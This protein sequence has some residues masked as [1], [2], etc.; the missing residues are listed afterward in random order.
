MDQ[1]AFDALWDSLSEIA[2]P[3][4]TNPRYREGRY[5]QQDYEE[6]NRFVHLLND[7]KPQR[8]LEIG[9]ACGG[10][11]LLWR[12]IAPVVISIDLEPVGSDIAADRFQDVT[13][14]LGDSHDPNILEQA[15][16]FAPYDMLFIDGDHSTEGARRDYDMYA[17]LVREGGIVAFHDYNYHHVRAAIDSIDLPKEIIMHKPTTFAIAIIRK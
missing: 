12:A 16:A 15:K 9:N 13:F 3:T 17:P 14:I 6:M 11:T 2:D 10:T 5:I 1:A 7:L 4:I 8:I